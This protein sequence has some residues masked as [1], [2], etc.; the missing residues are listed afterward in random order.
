MED[1][2][3]IKALSFESNA[4]AIIS[5]PRAVINNFSYSSSYA[6]CKIRGSSQL[7]KVLMQLQIALRYDRRCFDWIPS[8]CVSNPPAP[9]CGARNKLGPR[10]SVDREIG[11]V[12]R[13]DRQRLV[14]RE[15]IRGSVLQ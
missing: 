5:P 13:A 15:L 12:P 8:C 2:A 7:S 4:C 10:C 14:G 9:Q 6:C 3:F 1:T 11:A